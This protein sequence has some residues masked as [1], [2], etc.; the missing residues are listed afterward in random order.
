MITEN[1]IINTVA[2]LC[3]KANTRLRPD[4]LRA[5]KAA[6]RREK[7]KGAKYALRV[8]IENASI[9]RGEGIALCQDTGMPVVF[10]ETGS[11]AALS[12]NIKNAIIRGVEKGYRQGF[13]RGSIIADPLTRKAPARPSPAVIHFD[14]VNGA[15]LKITVLPKGFGSENKSSLRMF[16]PTAGIEEIEEYIVDRVKDAGPDA[17]PPY[18]VGI[19]IGGTADYACLL[20][21]KALLRPL[22][23]RH[24]SYLI[25]GIE[26]DLLKRINKLGIGAAG[27][28]GSST[29]LA[30]AIEEFPTHI[31]GLAVAVNICC[32]A[33]RS[34]SAIIR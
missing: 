31:S 28:G 3:V 24:S 13:L 5:L 32:H 33:L 6:L 7:N 27:L 10:V 4:V 21:K 18:I 8:L 19:G 30:A 23:K 1:K 15:S 12:G 11:R 29:C 22:D 34:A 16:K 9:A 26:K 17:C 20:A 25:A 2:G 14:Y